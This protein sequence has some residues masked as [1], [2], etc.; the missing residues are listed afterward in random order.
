MGMWCGAEAV[1][2]VEGSNG[3]TAKARGCRSH[4][5][6]SRRHVIED[7][8]RNLGDL[9][10]SPQGVEA[11]EGKPEEAL[12]GGKESDESVVPRKQ[13]NACGGKGLTVRRTG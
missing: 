13:G 3:I 1:I 9:D 8:P 2:I 4:R 12:R 5:G 6:R 11:D 10:T 7:L